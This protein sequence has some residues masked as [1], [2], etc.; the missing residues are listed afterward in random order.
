MFI[1]SVVFI[2]WICI[3]T[4]SF[5][6]LT[7]PLV[8]MS[9]VPLTHIADRAVKWTKLFLRDSSIILFPAVESESSWSFTCVQFHFPVIKLMNC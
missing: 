3:L 7:V 5:T 1:A 6:F 4:F 8:E 2:H 9:S